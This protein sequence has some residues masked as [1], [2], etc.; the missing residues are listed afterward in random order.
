VGIIVKKYGGYNCEK[1]K[2]KYAR[3]I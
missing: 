3:K 2:N 1:E